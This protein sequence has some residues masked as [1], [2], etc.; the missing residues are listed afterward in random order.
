MTIVK[1]QRATRSNCSQGSECQDASKDQQ[2]FK[3]RRP[4]SKDYNRNRIEDGRRKEGTQY[5]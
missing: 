3:E 4:S 1:G 2:S 5:W